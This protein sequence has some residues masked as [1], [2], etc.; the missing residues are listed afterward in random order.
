MEQHP[1]IL[2]SGEQ[3][4]NY[5]I[6][7]FLGAGGF[8]IT[9]RAIDKSLGCRVAIKEYFPS[10]WATRKTNS[11]HV[12][13]RDETTLS[14]YQYGLKYFLEEART[15]AQFKNNHIVRVSRFVEANNTAYI[16][17]DY[18]EGL[19]LQH[20]LKHCHKL[21]EKEIRLIA[22]PILKGLQ[23][24][25]G[26][27]Y[28]HRD[29][30]PS[31]IY[32][33][34]NGSPVLI[35]FGSARNEMSNMSNPLN[36][37]VTAGYTPCEQYNKNGKQGPWT[38][39]YSLGATLYQCISGRK[40]TLSLERVAAVD[41]GQQDPLIPASII[42]K[43]AYSQELL[44]TIDHMLQIDRR[45]RPASTSELMPLFD[46]SNSDVFEE[47][48]SVLKNNNIDWDPELLRKIE[49]KL[50]NYMGPLA[51]MLTRQ[52]SE[53]SNTPDELLQTLAESIN[54]PIEQAKFYKSFRQIAPT[55]TPISTS[56]ASSKNTSSV[57]LDS[58]LNDKFINSAK[59]GLA[60]YIGPIAHTLVNNAI[61]NATDYD[62]LLQQLACEIPG[63]TERNNFIRQ[64]ETQQ[65]LYS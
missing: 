5:T 52:A 44:S 12:V 61:N 53:I 51:S 24:I 50:T 59:E 3:I 25:H 14:S 8:G 58:I 49:H 42:G 46:I 10:R 47:Y 11:R 56:L 39:I 16:I 6:E 28:L 36:R 13:H 63:N 38:D 26:G 32:L 2:S 55:S 7:H 34:K 35:D 45:D 31:N 54:D 43:N 4:E 65:N 17:M 60:F 33:R 19:S 22:K 57:E 37:V 21:T 23:T 64:L 30:K 62:S 27:R 15:L 40:P 9:Y 1:F 18:E 20:F 29:I 48:D 41:N